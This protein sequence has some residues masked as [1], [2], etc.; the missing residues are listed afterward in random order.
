MKKIQQRFVRKGEII[1]SQGKFSSNAGRALVD[2]AITLAEF[3]NG[4]DI[5][6]AY[7]VAGSEHGYHSVG[8]EG[9]IRRT[10]ISDLEEKGIVTTVSVNERYIVI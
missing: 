2:F 4:K 1:I 9:L 5:F 3:N 10:L 7:A 6:Y 8:D